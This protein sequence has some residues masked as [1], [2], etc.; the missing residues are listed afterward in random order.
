MRYMNFSLVVIFTDRKGMRLSVHRGS[1]SEGGSTS[2]VGVCFW[3]GG[4]CLGRSGPL[5][6]KN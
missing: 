2:S 1:A 5:T 3:S 4:I 6:M